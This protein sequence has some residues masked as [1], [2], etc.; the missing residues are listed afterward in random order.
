MATV[1]ELVRSIKGSLPLSDLGGPVVAKWIDE[2]YKEMVSKVRFKHL[3]TTGELVVPGY[4]DTGTV[5]VSRGAE[6]VVGLSTVW[7]AEPTTSVAD[8]WFFRAGTAWYRV[9]SVTDN[10]NLTLDS[11]YAE[12]GLTSVVEPGSYTWSNTSGSEYR[13]NDLDGDAISI[14]DT[15][16][17]VYGDGSAFSE[18]PGG[19]LAVSEWA[20][21]GNNLYVRLADSADPDSK[22]SAFVTYDI[23]NSDGTTTG[24]SYKLV[25][26]YYPLASDARWL[27]TFVHSRTRM[28]LS[29]ETPETMDVIAPGRI[30]I[31]GYPSHI[32]LI[33][34]DATNGYLMVE[35]YP[36]PATSEILHYIYWTLPS[37]L[38]MASDIP[39]QIDDNMLKE[40]AMVDAYRWAK[41]TSIEKGNVE[42]AGFYGNW[43]DRQRTIWKR[44]LKD[45]QRTDRGVDDTTLILQLGKGGSLPGAVRTARDH[46]VSGWTGLG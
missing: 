22:R 21:S 30:H 39:L 29:I 28:L 45:A 23:E 2:R 12:A 6:E 18:G 34:R 36:P 17:A 8:E 38:V 35:V 43:E 1:E 44:S 46:I 20:Q 19:S 41:I 40:G 9:A 24:N 3:R 31:G 14:T 37:A 42:A 16:S 15:I 4:V 26:R 5:H 7:A 32:S 33:G 10:T 25:K 27:G 13:L 11:P